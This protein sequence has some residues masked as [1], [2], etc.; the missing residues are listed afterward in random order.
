M[1]KFLYFMLC[2]I[3]LITSLGKFPLSHIIIVILGFIIIIK[4]LIYKK[5]YINFLLLIYLFFL[6]TQSVSYWGLDSGSNL[7]SFFSYYFVSICNFLLMLTLLN[8]NFSKNRFQ[9]MLVIASLIISS[10]TIFYVYLL[11]RRDISLDKIIE[12]RLIESAIGATNYVASTISV[13]LPHSVLIIF[14]QTNIIKKIFLILCILM[15]MIAV[16][17][18]F[19]RNGYISFILALLLSFYFGKKFKNNRDTNTSITKYMILFIFLILIIFIKNSLF[20]TNFLIR[21]SNI[22]TLSGRTIIW[23]ETIKIFLESNIL[24]GLGTGQLVGYTYSSFPHNIFLQTLVWNGILGFISFSIIFVYVII[25]SVLILRF[26]KKSKIDM[27][28][29]ASAISV[30]VGLLASQFEIT[31]NTPIFDVFFWTNVSIIEKKG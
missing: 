3:M 19:S 1:D 14:S 5:L 30:L 24:F 7:H 4:F 8:I 23:R 16:I 26:I 28:H 25:K 20:F 13:L 22:G 17:L 12:Y 29:I 18:T 21:W 27:I 2:L 9:L 15:Q 10:S 31:I 11:L 6:F